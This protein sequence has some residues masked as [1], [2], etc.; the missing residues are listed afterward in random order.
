MVARCVATGSGAP[1][2]CGDNLPAPREPADANDTA[3]QPASHTGQPF[4]IDCLPVPIKNSNV[5]VSGGA[6]KQFLS[7]P[8][9]RKREQYV[10][11]H[12]P[13]RAVA[14]AHKE[15]DPDDGGTG[16]VERSAARSHGVHRLEFARSVHVPEL[17]STFSVVGAEMT[18]QASGKDTARNRPDRL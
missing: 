6:R 11:G 14:R 17:A 8:V 13:E 2:D 16:S 12:E 3:K 1:V 15:H 5:I 4:V 9:N 18:V 10:P 7:L